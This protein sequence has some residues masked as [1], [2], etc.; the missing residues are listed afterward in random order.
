MGQIVTWLV[1]IIIVCIRL[2]L[3]RIHT[4]HG[5]IWPTV[6]CL[7]PTKSREQS[8]CT[9]CLSKYTHVTHSRSVL[10][11][12]WY[13][14]IMNIVTMKHWPYVWIFS[15]I[16]LLVQKSL[17]QKY[18][19]IS[20]IKSLQLSTPSIICE[21]IV[22]MCALNRQSYQPNLA[23]HTSPLWICNCQW[24]SPSVAPFFSVMWYK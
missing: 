8:F 22:I 13:N 18:F 21:K 2:A 1:I 23:G 7:V 20:S 11:G 12:V 24:A 17:Q 5:G 9:C 10:N 16:E 19:T 6:H 4:V 15:T 3:A 14:I